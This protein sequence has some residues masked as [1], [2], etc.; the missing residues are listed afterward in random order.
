MSSLVAASGMMLLLG[1]VLERRWLRSKDMALAFTFGD[2]ALAFG[3]ASGVLL[4]GTHQPCGAIG[5]ASQLVVAVAWLI[6]GLWQWKAEVSAGVYTRR[7]ASAP[8]RSGINWSYTQLSEPGASS[9][10]PAD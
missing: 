6:F 1:L 5:P 7:Q 8:R 3:I 2:P 10:S 4:I 9:L